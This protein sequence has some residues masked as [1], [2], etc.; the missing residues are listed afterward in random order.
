MNWRRVRKGWGFSGDEGGHKG[1][2]KRGK[3]AKGGKNL[4]MGVKVVPD[5]NSQSPQE[6]GG[7]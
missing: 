3:F 4:E 6:G 2:S 5:I 7:G 1:G